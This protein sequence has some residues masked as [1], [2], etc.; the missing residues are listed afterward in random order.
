MNKESLLQLIKESKELLK[1]AS[2]EQKVRLL[3]AL[4]HTYARLQEQKQMPVEVITETS[5]DYLEER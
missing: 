5:P 1:T 3:K 2:P 4:E